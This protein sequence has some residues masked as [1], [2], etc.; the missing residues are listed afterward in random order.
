M[1]IF[2]NADVTGFLAL[3]D[4]D[5]EDDK[6]GK[7]KKKKVKKDGL[8]ALKKQKNDPNAPAPNRIPFPDMRDV[9]KIEKAKVLKEGLRRQGLH[10]ISMFLSTFCS[11]NQIIFT[12][13]PSRSRTL[14][15]LTL[16]FAVPPSAYFCLG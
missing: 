8:A 15:G 2:P 4:D 16:I 7:P 6:D 3:P 11:I 5:D 9:D 12:G 13:C 14:V 1:L 10:T